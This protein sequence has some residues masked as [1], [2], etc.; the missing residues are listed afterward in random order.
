MQ[1]DYKEYPTL[2]WNSCTN[3]PETFQLLSFFVLEN[4]IEVGNCY[5]ISVFRLFEFPAIR[6]AVSLFQN[7]IDITYVHNV[8]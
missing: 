5:V 6:L 2:L 3:V 8:L 1:H 4:V 7:K